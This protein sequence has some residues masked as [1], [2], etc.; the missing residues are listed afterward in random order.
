MRAL[1]RWI[2]RRFLGVRPNLRRVPHGT[3]R[4][5]SGSRWRVD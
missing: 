3:R 4:R 5:M 2:V 1:L